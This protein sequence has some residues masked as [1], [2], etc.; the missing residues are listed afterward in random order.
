MNPCKGNQI[1]QG[2]KDC[3]TVA[4]I[5]TPINKYTVYAFEKMHD[6][7]FDEPSCRK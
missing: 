4:S 2:H 1:I 5:K 3:K 6:N 7:D